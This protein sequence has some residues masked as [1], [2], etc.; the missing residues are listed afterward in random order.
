MSAILEKRILPG[1][2]VYYEG[3]AHHVK[4]IIGLDEVV[5][6]KVDSQE[7]VCTKLSL[8]DIYEP[9]SHK[10]PEIL[11]LTNDEWKLIQYRYQIIE[12]LVDNPNR[13]RQMVQDR[14][15]ENSVSTNTVYNWL[16]KYEH[17]GLLTSLLPKKRNDTGTTNFSDDIEKVI[18]E[19]IQKEYLDDRQKTV[20]KVCEEVRR[21]CRKKGL[22][23]PHRNTIRNRIKMLD[24]K[25][26]MKARYSNQEAAHYYRDIKGEFPHAD[27]PLRV[28]QI[29]HT[30]LDIILVDDVHRIQIGRPFITLAMC[31][32]TRLCFS[33]WV[34]FENPSSLSV[35]LTIS[36]GIL[37]KDKFLEKVGVEGKWPVW[38]VPTCI[39][40][41]N[42][43]E[44]RGEMLKM[45]CKQHNVRI[46][47]RPVGKPQY[48]AHIER[49][50]GTFLQEIHTLP[51][52]TSSSVAKKGSYD[53]EKK[54]ALTL[55]E[56]E[57]WLVN[58]IVNVY[59][60]REHSSLGMSPLQKLEEGIHG[61]ETT[62]GVGALAKIKTENEERFK[63]DFM[64]HVERT[65][66]NYGIVWNKIHYYHD[67]LR[68]WINAED[69]KL[70]KYKKKFIIKY[71][72][73]DISVIYFYDPELND[74]F[75]IPYRDI[76]KPM[77]SIWE[78][79]EVKKHLKQQNHHEIDE[80]IIF[81]AFERMREI[82]ESAVE[83][84]AKARRK[85]Q[86]RSQTQ[87]RRK[88]TPNANS[89]NPPEVDLSF[90][91]DELEPFDDIDEDF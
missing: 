54:A 17:S 70:N 62:P 16:K 39:H 4:S 80:E 42:A 44:F 9:L 58:Y 15:K 34:G 64:P 57:E 91:V 78:L 45:A 72:P 3:E 40:A 13:N 21:A 26:V 81:N 66:Q 29:D 86:T 59:H 32:K 67:V 10:H 19:V 60:Q 52:T 84:T 53:P 22:K 14:G 7:V 88:S 48:G 77:M 12:P 8:V 31:I 90:D 23:A 6:I 20:A 89:E 36:Q 18:S 27:A 79:R 55:G 30:K 82:E 41:D 28:I 69:E 51:G 76:S 11:N 74:Y 43:K 65:V 63:L 61:N 68:P 56:F 2:R 50:L 25:D 71:D 33:V 35:G 83:K 5:L 38:G 37:A 47:W 75:P 1:M 24:S 46:E 49:L 85:R 73:R 87:T